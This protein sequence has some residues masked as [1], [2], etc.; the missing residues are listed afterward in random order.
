METIETSA[1][2]K[3]DGV[4]IDLPRPARHHNVIA[5]ICEEPGVKYVGSDS[6]QGFITSEG[7]FVDRQEAFA[8]AANAGQIIIQSNHILFSE[9]L[10]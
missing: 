6:V 7:R 4:V 10:W 5:K 2:K 8:I 3:P 1:V 9:D